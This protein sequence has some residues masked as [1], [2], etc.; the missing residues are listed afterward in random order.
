[1]PAARRAAGGV[2]PVR[3]EQGFPARLVQ[4]MFAGRQ[5]VVNFAAFVGYAEL[6]P[7]GDSMSKDSLRGSIRLPK[8]W[9]SQVRSAVV[10]AISL[11]KFTPTPAYG[12]ETRPNGPGC[13]PL[14]RIRRVA[15]LCATHFIRPRRA[16]HFSTAVHTCAKMTRPTRRCMRLGTAGSAESDRAVNDPRKPRHSVG[17]PKIF[18]ERSFDD[19]VLASFMGFEF[20]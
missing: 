20:L 7:Q 16:L 10:R 14:S 4:R 5:S 17:Q 19:T 1:M 15:Q 13:D 12:R 18:I 2:V 6:R 9:K 8:S 11:A 3:F